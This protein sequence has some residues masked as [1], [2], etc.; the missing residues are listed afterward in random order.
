MLR[1]KSKSTWF[2][3]TSLVLYIMAAFF[4]VNILALTAWET[5]PTFFNANYAS[6]FFDFGLTFLTMPLFYV[7]MLPNNSY[8]NKE[9]V[10]TRFGSFERYCTARS[11]VI[12]LE[13]F[14]YILSLYLLLFIRA[15]CFNQTNQFLMHS[16]FL[17]KAAISQILCLYI[18]AMLDCCT[19][20]LTGHSVIGFFVSYFFV[21]Y[22]YVSLQ[23]QIP[24]LFVYNTMA[25]KPVAMPAYL[26]NLFLIFV[27][28]ILTAFTFCVIAKRKDYLLRK[29][30][31]ETA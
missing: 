28:D 18:L 31:G 4:N 8:F 1:M 27:I 9:C 21:A 2:V 23:L 26:P 20:F 25:I 13:C 29:V 16:G 5:H 17:L 19:A 3:F 22:D 30:H 24:G 12:L 10:F 14:A 6:L 15:V 7:F 11:M